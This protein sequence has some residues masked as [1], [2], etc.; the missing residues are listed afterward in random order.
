MATEVD[1]NSQ[2]NH[3]DETRLGDLASE[4]D[5]AVRVVALTQ[6]LVDELHVHSSSVPSVRLD[7]SIDRDLGLDSLA[8]AELISRVE[9]EFSVIV[10]DQALFSI[11]TL[12]DVL[13]TIQSA[14]SKGVPDAS[15][16]RDTAL[17]AVDTLPDQVQTLQQLLDWHA[18][19]HPQR[20]HLYVYQDEENYTEVS[21]ASLR[22]RAKQFA[23]GLLKRGV[24][25][26]QRI[27]I[28]LPTC[29]DYFYCFY[30]VLYARAIPVPIY[31]PAR[32]SQIEDHLM[33]HASI[34]N[35]AGVTT[36]ITVKEAEPLSQLL[37][38]QVPSLTTITTPAQLRDSDRLSDVGDARAEDIAFL[39]Y[40]S[41]STGTP[42]GVTLTHANLLAN[43]RAMGQVVGAGPDE[44]A[45]S[46]LPVYHDM[47]LIG[48]WFGSLY[49]A[50]PLVI[51]SPLAFLSRPKRWLQAI[52]RHKGTL[53][54]A[55]NFAYELCA[56]KVDDDELDELDLSSW[57]LS[58]NGAEPVSPA[59]IKHFSE[60]FAPCGYRPETMSPVY[61][62]A[63]S[64]VGLVFP[65]Q[66]RLPVINRFEREV[67]ARHGRAVLCSDQ[68]IES[69]EL[70]ALGVPLPGHQV[71]IVDEFG[72]ELAE[73]E[74]GAVEFKGPSATQG[75]FNE[76]DK[77][78]QLFNHGWLV[79]GDRG[80]TLDGELYLTGRSKDI[81]I[82]AGRN[83]YPQQLEAA[84]GELEGVRN[85]CVAVFSGRDKRS[86]TERLIVVAEYKQPCPLP[87]AKLKE[88]IKLLSLDVLDTSVDEVVLCPAHAIPKTSSGKVRRAAC[89]ELYQAG[90]L[91]AQQTPVWLQ[92]VHLAKAGL[93]PAMRTVSHRTADVVQAAYMWL[94]FS[95]IAPITWLFVALTT[96]PVWCWRICRLACRL[97][98]RLS[99]TRLDKKGMEHL[100]ESDA[101]C[102]LVSNHASYLDGVALIAALRGRYR[103]VAK[104]ELKQNFFAR[105]FLERLG[106]EF[107]ERF[108]VQKGLADARRLSQLADR[109][110]PLFIFPEGRFERMAGLHEFHMGAFIAAAK[111]EIPV[112]PISVCGT[113]SK[114]RGKSLF[115]RRGDITV[116]VCAPVFPGGTDWSAAVV[117]RDEVRAA[118]LKYCH[119]PDLSHN[120]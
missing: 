34:L 109:P 114:L 112:I 10:P 64:S 74:E 47:G 40:T 97:L 111:S 77:T 79:T 23:C 105:V 89:R 110:E 99:G 100:P 11:D 96:N 31:P 25:P 5:A 67:L 61:G 86:E 29:E 78:R 103:F 50:M 102:M 44:V 108:D 2:N 58:W 94:L 21:Y 59:T 15:V 22:E 16:S 68:N 75:Y 83:I 24:E 71:R 37:S 56:N 45:V 14:D 4:G 1:S 28:M 90:E 18:I 39:Q 12:A 80:F 48:A 8:R 106:C 17:D 118:I 107:V 117:L 46:W 9:N 43:I 57:R 92:A 35:N 119:E 85:G 120:R 113:R 38:M 91:A 49:H 62:L 88:Q 51:M 66:A 42:K 6:K 33:R 30:G 20:P 69:V 65:R 70:V 32:L 60:K 116:T 72:N 87:E 93:M 19:R 73:C 95:F 63:E 41:G 81:I 3:D 36:L 26:G 27:A 115:P 98:I 101:P 7:A 55:P 52:S 54:P 53:S 82:R 13:A 104:A 76:P 84:V